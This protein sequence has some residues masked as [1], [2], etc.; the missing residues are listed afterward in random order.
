MVESSVD[1]STQCGRLISN[2]DRIHWEAL[3]HALNIEDF[4]H[5]GRGFK[6]SWD[7]G[8]M[9]GQRILA[10]LD[11]F[12]V[13]RNHPPG[14]SRSITQYAIQ[15]DGTLS[16]HLPFDIII[17]LGDAPLKRGVWKM[18]IGYLEDTKKEVKRIWLSLDSN[19]LSFFAKIRRVIK[20]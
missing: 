13:F 2:S 1:K 5:H 17:K 16:D 18:N 7:N 9:E 8:R 14:S 20:F 6:Y 10:R 11:C 3:K 4:F 15:G 12:Y 19:R